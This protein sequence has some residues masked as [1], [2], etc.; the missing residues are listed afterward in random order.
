MNKEKYFDP[1]GIWE[2]SVIDQ[3]GQVLYNI[4]KEGH[5]I[6]L[7]YSESGR[8]PKGGRLHFS[9]ANTSLNVETY[10]LSNEISLSVD[11]LGSEDDAMMFTEGVIS[12]KPLKAPEEFMMNGSYC[13]E[14]LKFNLFFPSEKEV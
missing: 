12:K 14:Y 11:D 4:I 6:D 9:R 2:I 7:A 8:P 5:I 3:S 10:P 13:G 1:Y